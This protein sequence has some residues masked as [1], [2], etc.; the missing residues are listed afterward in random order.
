MK[1]LFLHFL[2]LTLLFGCAS[3]KSNTPA[4][5]ENPPAPFEK[6]IFHT[7]MC[8]GSCPVYHL[9][10][11]GNKNVKLQKEAI[12]SRGM[13]VDSSKVGYFKGTAD[14]ESF[15]TLV[16]EIQTIGIDTVNFGNTH[17]CDG[18]LKT[19]IVYHDGKRRFMESM[20]PPQRTQNLIAALYAICEKSKLEKTDEKF[21]IESSDK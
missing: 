19:I 21:V 6:V 12:F 17:C 7:G 10:V 15:N 5:T 2:L 20:F 16:H 14:E 8:F 4:T 11:D 9:E 3:K 13:Q 1:N 18:S